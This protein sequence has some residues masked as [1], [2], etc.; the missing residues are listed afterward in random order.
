M[1]CC[2]CTESIQRGE[3]RRHR[4]RR[5]PPSDQLCARC[6]GLRGGEMELRALRKKSELAKFG[7][8]GSRRPLLKRNDNRG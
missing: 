1:L 5:G 6:G 8:E 2:A 4:S 7:L 3:R